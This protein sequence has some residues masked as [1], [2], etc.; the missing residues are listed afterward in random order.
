MT[1]TAASDAHRI[2]I[3]TVAKTMRVLFAG[4]VI[5]ESAGV[6]V[7]YEGTIPARFYFPQT[8]V[9]MA[10]LNP[11]PTSTH[12]PFKGD[13]NYWSVKVGEVEAE[14]AVWSYLEPIPEMA[15]IAGLLCFYDAKVDA[16]EEVTG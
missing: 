2:T 16:I 6:K 15:E 9:A 13:A 12:C 8:D 3:E 5:A 11:T 14:D 1:D 10:R 4:E 7:L